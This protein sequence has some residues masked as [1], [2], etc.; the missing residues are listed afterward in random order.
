MLH[1]QKRAL[2]ILRKLLILLPIFPSIFLV[3]FF[4]RKSG[5]EKNNKRDFKVN[6]YNKNNGNK[7]KD[8]MASEQKEILSKH[9]EQITRKKTLSKLSYLK[10]S[11][12][13]NKPQTPLLSTSFGKYT[14]HKLPTKKIGKHQPHWDVTCT[15]VG[16]NCRV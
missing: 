7:S 5:N 4:I 11:Y 8:E 16:Y 1:I 3:Y 9:I 2:Q 6:T 14:C 10:K 15:I 13:E 12:L